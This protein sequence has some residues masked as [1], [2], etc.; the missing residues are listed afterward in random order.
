MIIIFYWSKTRLYV[1]Y[2]IELAI[3]V[4][5]LAGLFFYQLLSY[6]HYFNFDDGGY[7]RVITSRRSR[8]VLSLLLVIAV[9]AQFS[10]YVYSQENM[11]TDSRRLSLD[12]V[13]KASEFVREH[14]RRDQEV[15]TQQP[16]FAINAQRRNA[17]DL[18]RRFYTF[19][20]DPTQTAL[21]R[22]LEQ[23]D[24]KFVIT[25]PRTTDLLMDHPRLRQCI[26]NEYTLV[27][28]IPD[29]TSGIQKKIKIYRRNGTVNC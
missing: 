15:F 9:M 12:S 25:S 5:L 11:T 2:F 18:S 26:Q 10:L 21:I 16:A 24:V 20:T 8:R 29:K 4:S 27:K 19:P 17:M 6:R 13:T 7:S 1:G 23:N 22:Y 14:S 28:S 3:P